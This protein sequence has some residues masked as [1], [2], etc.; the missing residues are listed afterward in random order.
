M[1]WVSNTQHVLPLKVADFNSDASSYRCLTVCLSEWTKPEDLS[2][3][4]ASSLPK[5]EKKERV[6]SDKEKAKAA[7]R[8][9]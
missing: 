9:K 8:R 4:C 6:L 3:A 5:K 2:G 7:K 1:H